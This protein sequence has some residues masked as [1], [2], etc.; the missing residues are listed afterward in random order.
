ME[1]LAGTLQSEDADALTSLGAVLPVLSSWRRRQ[2]ERS[3]VDAWRYQVT[4]KPVAARR[5]EAAL[6]GRWLVVT[7]AEEVDGALAEGVVRTL[8]ARGAEVQRVELAVGDRTGMAERLAEAVADAP[9]AGVFALPSLAES[10]E[11]AEST[12]VAEGADGLVR[13]AAL[14]QALGDLGVDAPLWVATRG[15]VSTGRA[16]GPVDPSQ[17]RVG[18]WAGSRPWNWPSDGAVSSICRRR[19]TTGRCRGWRAC[20]PVAR[21]RTRWR[22]APPA[23]SAAG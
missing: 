23:S 14:A 8:S 2:G 16:D 13:T 22:C 6:T 12:E 19:W 10:A 3:T 1:A 5:A 18:A 11:G 4:W 21:A 17:A 15:A 20:W 7:A 9:P